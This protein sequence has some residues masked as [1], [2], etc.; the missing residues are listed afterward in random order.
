MLTV[1]QSAA[2]NPTSD[3]ASWWA[4][5]GLL[6]EV[7]NLC[8]PPSSLMYLLAVRG[9]PAGWACGLPCAVANAAAE[10][11]CACVRCLGWS[12]QLTLTQQ[13]GIHLTARLALLAS[14]HPLCSAHGLRFAWHMPLYCSLVSLQVQLL[15][16]LAVGMFG[17]TA[18]FENESLFEAPM[19]P[20]LILL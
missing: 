10:H 5:R 19:V 4:L 12:T 6:L 9:S 7:Y 18:H 20:G 11:G 16:I 8:R 1:V 3:R 14:T 2:Y 15:G 17:M 13:W